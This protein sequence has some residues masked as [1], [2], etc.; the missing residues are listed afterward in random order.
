MPKLRVLSGKDVVAILETFGFAVERQ[1]GSHVKL[2]RLQ[3][4]ARQ[5]L[6]IPLHTELDKGTLRAIY[7]QIL[8]YIPEKDIRLH[9]Y[10][11]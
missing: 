6:T 3:N 7:H 2:R 4:G 5:T 8:R 10:T 9:V 11:E 1:R